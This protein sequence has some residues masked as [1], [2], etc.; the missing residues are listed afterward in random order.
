MSENVEKV[1]GE[2]IAKKIKFYICETILET[3]TKN[4]RARDDPQSHDL[5]SVHMSFPRNKLRSLL[6]G[7]FVPPIFLPG[8]ETGR[9]TQT[10]AASARQC[11]GPFVS[12]RTS[13]Y[14]LYGLHFHIRYVRLN[15]VRQKN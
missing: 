2:E 10:I 6:T 1:G 15:L 11:H 4:G 14:K 3:W 13:R 8:S 5:F 12:P 7:G 9:L